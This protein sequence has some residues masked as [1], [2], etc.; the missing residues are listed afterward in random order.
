LASSPK[1][2]VL[3]NP[4]EN[5]SAIEKLYYQTKLGQTFL[6]AINK[7]NEIDDQLEEMITGYLDDSIWEDALRQGGISVSGSLKLV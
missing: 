2:G 6:N 3:K 5:A 1:K 4:L 7:A